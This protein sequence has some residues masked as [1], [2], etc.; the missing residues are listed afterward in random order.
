MKSINIA[1]NLMNFRMT[2]LLV[3]Y[4]TNTDVDFS[5]MTKIVF[6]RERLYLSCSG[7]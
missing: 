1:M 2:N 6:F 4:N 3:D 5:S 7:V